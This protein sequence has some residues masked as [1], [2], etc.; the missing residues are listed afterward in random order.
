[1]PGAM[2]YGSRAYRP[3]RMVIDAVTST[4]AVSTPSKGM[5]VPS[6][7]ST[8]GFTATMYAVARNEVRPAVTSVRRDGTGVRSA[9]KGLEE[10]LED[11][12]HP[13]PAVMGLDK[14][15]A[16]RA[17]PGGERLVGG[18]QRQR[19]HEL[20]GVVIVQAAVGAAGL[21]EQHLAAAVDQR[22]HAV[23]PGL[24]EDEAQALVR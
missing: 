11:G 23:V 13:R 21:P 17:E 16:L 10:R 22:G 12:H 18:Q 14:R 8:A 9:D 20:V 5:P 4:V 19:L 15:A 3:I 1:M 6:V 2:T 7:A 24:E